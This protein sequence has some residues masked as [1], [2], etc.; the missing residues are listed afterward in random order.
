MTSKKTA[1][2]VLIFA[3][4]LLAAGGGYFY[5]IHEPLVSGAISD[6]LDEM[7]GGGEDDLTDEESLCR[8]IELASQLITIRYG[9]SVFSCMDKEYSRLP[10]GLWKGEA[11]MCWVLEADVTAGFNMSELK[12]Q[13]HPSGGFVIEAEE[14]RILGVDNRSSRLIYS[15][16]GEKFDWTERDI[17]PDLNSRLKT[18]AEKLG[19]LADAKSS[20]KLLAEGLTVKYGVPVSVEYKSGE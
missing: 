1:L 6:S 14:P 18:E 11:R 17:F 13:P 15:Q 4:V 8:S 2:F 19:I 10:W 12:V 9:T 5:Y 3:L 20:L 7:T 16:A